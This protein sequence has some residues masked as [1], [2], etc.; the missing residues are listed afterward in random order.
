MKKNV[1]RR[2]VCA[3]LSALVIVSS[4]G[5]SVFADENEPELDEDSIVTLDDDSDDSDVGG[6]DTEQDEQDNGEDGFDVSDIEVNISDDSAVAGSSEEKL[7]VTVP[8]RNIRLKV[9]QTNKIVIGKTFQIKYG[10]TPLKSDDYVT[11]RN[12]NKGIVKVDENGLVTAVGYGEA[13]IQ[14]ETTSGKKKNVYFIVTD[15][16][17]NENADAVEGEIESIEFADSFVMLRAG[18]DFQAEPI[19]YPLGMYSELTYSSSDTDVASVSGSGKVKGLSAGSAVITARAENGVTAEFSVTVYDDVL[20]GIDVSKWQGDINWKKV[21]VSGVDYV[22]IRSSFGSEHIDECLEKNVAGCEKYGIPY[23]FYHYT[24]AKTPEEARY[25]AKFFLNVIRE[26]APE[27]PIVLDIE[28]EFYKKMEREQV[29]E[30]MTAFMDVLEDAGYYAMV[31][32][33]PNFIKACIDRSV[34]EK[35]DIWIACWGDEDRLNSFY[36]G[37]YGMWQYS[38]TGKVNGISG[39]VDL[40]YS[41]KDYASIIRE[42]GFN[43]L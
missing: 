42:N 7:E 33:A 24:Y 35:Y 2:F 37:K 20:R 41:Y 19:F 29:T 18:K 5:F 38:A 36:D 30:I 21:S 25:E 22:M 34:L 10:F 14:L 1:I 6:D 31:Y 32:N 28:E 40:D 12:F 13:K 15:E 26:Y 16:E 8:A 17:G 3:A 4:A 11:Y 27:Y 9:K 43:K 23:G 39:D